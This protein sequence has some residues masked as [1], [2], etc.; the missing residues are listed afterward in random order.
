MIEFHEIHH[1]LVVVMAAIAV[2]VALSNKRFLVRLRPP[3][4]I[5]RQ[6]NEIPKGLVS[7]LVPARDE[8]ERIGQCLK[9]LMSDPY[10]NLEVVVLDDNS[11]DRTAEI[12]LR[13]ASKDNRI[14]LIEG[15]EL[16]SGWIGKHWASHQLSEAAAGDY[17]LFIDADTILAQGTVESSLYEVHVRDADL[18]TA[19]PKRSAECTAERL[20]FPFIDWAVYCCL[21]IRAAHRV[22]NAYLSATFGQ[23]MFFNRRS[24]R[25]I[26]GHE[27]V[28]DNIIDDFELGR[29]TK[30]SGLR[31]V[32]MDGS[33][34][35]ESLPYGG[36][37]DA[38]RGVSRSVFPALNYHL[39]ILAV[40]SIVILALGFLPLLTLADA[41]I[42]NQGERGFVLIS[43]V[44]ILLMGFSWFLV[45][46][47]FNHNIL[48]VP[49]FPISIVV[50]VAVAYYSMFANAF[51]FATWKDR[52]MVGRRF[53]L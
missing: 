5:K 19:I 26:G 20:M 46:R 13:C 39:S 31:W 32:L 12:V 37:L 38:L 42:S 41:A 45:C 25:A 44:S 29:M 23:F 52:K 50:I 8:E 28:R 30:R 11:T 49:L 14:R 3:G 1:Y 27:A 7:I 6:E 53:R 35:V 21:P 15:D 17:L 43:L 18:L 40:F 34:V 4:D 48:L 36:D 22:K 51:K 33:E 2:M 9:S 47:R 24:Y 10:Q 16:P